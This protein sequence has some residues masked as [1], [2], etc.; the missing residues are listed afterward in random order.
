MNAFRAAG[1]TL[2]F[3]ASVIWESGL[4]W[5]DGKYPDGNIPFVYKWKTANGWA[6]PN[7]NILLRLAD[8]ILLQAEAKNE[9]NDL[10][11]AT[12]DLN[13]IRRRALLVDTKATSQ[14]QLR[15]SIAN[16]RRLELAFEGHRWLDLKRSGKAVEKLNNLSLNYNMTTE[17]L[18]FPIP[19][20]ELDRNPK[21]TQNPGY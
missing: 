8:I 14:E 4:P 16:E 5:N 21:L 13:T 1:D 3:N 12:L 6:S 9:L 10:V 11:G 20:N 2:R 18:L 17:K 19:Q 15:D 7:N